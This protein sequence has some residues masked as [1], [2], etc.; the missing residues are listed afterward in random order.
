[1]PESVREAAAKQS[2]A[3]SAKRDQRRGSK[4]SR[5]HGGERGSEGRRE[6]A[7]PALDSPVA[8]REEASRIWSRRDGGHGVVRPPWTRWTPGLVAAREVGVLGSGRVWTRF[9]SSAVV[10]ALQAEAVD[11]EDERLPH[12]WSFDVA[13]VESLGAVVSAGHGQAVGAW[14][15]GRPRSRS[16]VAG[17]QAPGH[18]FTSLRACRGATA[19]GMGMTHPRGALVA[20]TGWDVHRSTSTVAA[21]PVVSTGGAGVRVCGSPVMRQGSVGEI[22]FDCGWGEESRQLAVVGGAGVQVLDVPSLGQLGRWKTRSDALGCDWCEA[23]VVLAGLRDGG[24]V[25]VDVRVRDGGGRGGT[26]AD[27]LLVKDGSYR[28]LPQVRRV[29]AVDESLAVVKFMDRRRAEESACHTV[30]WDRRVRRAILAYGDVQREGSPPGQ[31]L[32]GL[33]QVRGGVSVSRPAVCKSLNLLAV[34]HRCERVD[35]GPQIVARIYDLRTGA[36]LRELNVAHRS[37]FPSDAQGVNDVLHSLSITSN[38]TLTFLPPSFDRVEGSASGGGALRLVAGSKM[39]PV[40]FCALS[41]RR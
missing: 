29:H 3:R 21:V 30:L 16:V 8:V 1:M 27:A 39:G 23:S 40:A 20:T 41:E 13:L 25:E 32:A 2:A 7:P 34:P 38:V 36:H 11:R 31:G 14:V 9:A 33:V 26:L 35:C 10:N 24:L 28:A 37:H 12:D 5:P 22:L 19:A 15:P 17:F 18:A 6:R 4:R